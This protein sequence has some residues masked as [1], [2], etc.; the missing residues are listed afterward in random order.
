MLPKVHYKAGWADTPQ[1]DSISESCAPYLICNDR[2]IL[3]SLS[4]VYN[5]AK[6]D[7][8]EN[9]ADWIAA[10]AHQAGR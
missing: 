9:F 3:S 6:H 1:N 5:W 8:Y 4:P 7:G 10:A 2:P